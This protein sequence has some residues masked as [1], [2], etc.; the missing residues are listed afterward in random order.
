MAAEGGQPRINDPRRPHTP[1]ST[2]K[3]SSGNANS[4]VTHTRSAKNRAPEVKTLRVPQKRKQLATFRS[5]RR[6]PELDNYPANVT[7]TSTPDGETKP[8][9]DEVGPAVTGAPP[10]GPEPIPVAVWGTGNMG[11]AAIRAIV[12]HRGLSLAAVIVS[13]EAKVGM[14]A[15]QIADLDEPTGVLCSNDRSGFI[16]RIR[17]GEIA[18]VAYMAS[19][20]F[21]PDDALDDVV[22][23]A[24]AGATIVLPGIYALYDPRNLAEP[25]RSRILTA[26]SDGGARVFASGV[27]PGWANDILPVLLG[28]VSSDIRQ[29]RA[30]EIFDYST[31]D[32]PDAVRYLVGMGQPMDSTPPMVLP[33]IPTMVWGGSVRM[34]ARGYGWTL[35]GITEHVE[36]LALERTT[37]NPLGVFEAG[38]QGALR[39]EVR[40]IV[41]GEE[42]IVIEHVTRIDP[43]C[44]P[45]W[46]QPTSGAG[47]HRVIVEGQPR[48]E[49]SIEAEAEDGNRSA[50]GN[51]TAAN[52]LINAIPWLTKAEPGIYDALDVP[53][54][55]LAPTL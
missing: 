51:A 4:T 6:Y 14:D 12:A 55:A 46:P 43:A 8:T 2:G 47:T 39:F 30:Q 25:L 5:I 21:R 35:D 40:G 23:C 34:I 48:I 52:R 50:G 29:I 13:A 38:T 17:S 24:A 27:D 28:G 1:A 53:L 18:A 7:T 45:E 11:R 49:V 31:Y 32:Q 22:H 9:V 3:Q 19:A 15:A 16:Q 26:V 54:A 42:R 20:D 33:S 36:R 44:A 10:T 37:S 41:N